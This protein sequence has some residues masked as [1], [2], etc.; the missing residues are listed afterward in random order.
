MLEALLIAGIVVAALACPVMTLLGRRGIGPGCA[1]MGCSPKQKKGET[2]DDLR[3]REHELSARI[4][5]IEAERAPSL[6]AASD[7]SWQGAET[8]R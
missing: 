3:R 8:P 2:L 4:A 5:E 6:A 1:M 7:G